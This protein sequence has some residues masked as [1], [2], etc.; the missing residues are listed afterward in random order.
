MKKISFAIVLA[1]FL[2]PLIKLAKKLK[3]GIGHSRW[4][5][6]MRMFP[7]IKLAKKL[8]AFYSHPPWVIEYIVSIN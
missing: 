6:M 4:E 3:D 2:F 1:L 8:K 7:L 5:T